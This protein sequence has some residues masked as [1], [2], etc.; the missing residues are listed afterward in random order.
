MDSNWSSPATLALLGAAGGFLDPNGGPSA[1]AHLGLQGLMAGNQFQQQRTQADLAKSK[2]AR[3]M[4]VEAALK[5]YS[6]KFGGDQVGLSRALVGSGHPDLI[7]L[8]IDISKAKSVKSYMKGLDDKGN[9]TYYA[10][11]NTGEVSPTGVT[12]AERLM[13]INRGSQIDLANP[14]TGEA[15]KSL[16]VG[17]N[18][19]QAAQL[20]QSQ[21]Q[22]NM[23]HALA[24]QNSAMNQYKTMMDY[25]PNYQAQKAGNIAGA[26][27]QATNSVQAKL[28]L[29]QVIEQGEQTIK[30]VDDLLKHP[31]FEISVGA[32]SPVGKV[33]SFIPGTDAASFDIASKQML[34][35][36]F[37]E[38]FQTLKGG[39]QI[40]EI[41]GKKATEAMSRMNT[42]NTQEEYI[43]SAKEFQSII[44]QGINR[45][46]SKA[47]VNQYSD[48]WGDIK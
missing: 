39:G 33:A 42:S 41:E 44:R 10:G 16:A 21:N 40:T 20:G 7:K 47:G 23:S 30:L 1:A 4:E 36:Q 27:L 8:G 12:P 9:P 22:F 13:Q 6:E 35:K 26:K 24:Q 17:I 28:D 2:L 11:Y 29:P 45:A 19:G 31:G 5:T 46:K 34:G 25:D 15:S 14:Y 3:Q 18:P 48:G 38:A 43:K 37:L 32:K